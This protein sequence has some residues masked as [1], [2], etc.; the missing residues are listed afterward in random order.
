MPY[1]NVSVVNSAFQESNFTRRKYLRI[2]ARNTEIP[3][4]VLL[5]PYLNFVSALFL[6]LLYQ[7]HT[8]GP[9]GSPSRTGPYM[10]KLCRT[11]CSLSVI[12]VG[13]SSFTGEFSIPLT[14]YTPFRSEVRPQSMLRSDVAN[15]V[16]PKVH[17]DLSSLCL[18][19]AQR[20][21]HNPALFSARDWSSRC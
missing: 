8:S 6:A 14:S 1:S 4:P 10:S 21:P 13:C 18:C 7:W 19:Y 20:A 12:L 9:C 3:T 5:E 11:K 2:C 16:A 15:R 17:S